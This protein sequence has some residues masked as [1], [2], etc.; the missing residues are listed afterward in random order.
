MSWSLRLRGTLIPKTL[1]LLRS[2]SNFE[3]SLSKEAEYLRLSPYSY[4]LM[5]T[6]SW[7]VK[8]KKRDPVTT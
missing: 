2:S 6:L 3:I 4:T 1:A 8:R 7:M 5:R